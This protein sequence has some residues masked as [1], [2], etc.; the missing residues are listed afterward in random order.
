MSN[1]YKKY[2]DKYNKII[3]NKLKNNGVYELIELWNKT[4]D[5][6]FKKLAKEII[7]EIYQDLYN[8]TNKR[9]YDYMK[10]NLYSNDYYSKKTQNKL[11]M[12]NKLT[13]DFNMKDKYGELWYLMHKLEIEK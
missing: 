10:D 6:R 7:K 11:E 5:I 1:E 9:Y 3:S 4:E 13:L 8:I 2:L 12:L